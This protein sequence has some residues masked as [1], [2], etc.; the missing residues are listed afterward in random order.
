MRSDPRFDPDVD[1]VLAGA[2]DIRPLPAG[3]RARAIA[4]ARAGMA[5]AAKAGFEAPLR[6]PRPRIV[7]LALAA[8]F[9]IVVVA[10]TAI[11]ALGIRASRQSVAPVPPPTRTMPAPAAALPPPALPTSPAV[12]QPKV[13]QDIPPM[14]RSSRPLRATTPQESY[15]AELELLTRAQVAYA[16]RDFGNALGLLAEHGRRFPS[17]RL[18]EEREALRVRSLTG[19]GR[20]EEAQRAAAAFAERFPRSVLLSRPGRVRP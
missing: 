3:V 8:S 10:A 4:R 1:A 9:A 20:T 6:T 19:A 14:A 15:A 17:G 7:V 11:A 18:T 13:D 2:K 16:G 5:T 12:D